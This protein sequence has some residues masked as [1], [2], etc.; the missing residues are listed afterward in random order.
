MMEIHKKCGRICRELH[1]VLNM[2]GVAAAFIKKIPKKLQSDLK[3]LQIELENGD[4]AQGEHRNLGDQVAGR[5]ESIMRDL[6]KFYKSQGKQPFFLKQIQSGALKLIEEFDFAFIFTWL[7]WPRDTEHSR[8]DLIESIIKELL[9]HKDIFEHV[10]ATLYS[11]LLNDANLVQYINNED[12]SAQLKNL[13]AM[14]FM[15]VF[16]HGNQELIKQTLAN[17]TVVRNLSPKNMVQ[18]FLILCS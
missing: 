14:L 10:Q 7:G 8:S 4:G 1:P 16:V 12:T 5:L 17:S 2:E 9:L 15:P 11:K 18:V 3:K 6:S 13:Y